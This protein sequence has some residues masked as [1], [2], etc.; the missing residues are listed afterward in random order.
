MKIEDEPLD[1]FYPKCCFCGA[2]LTGKCYRIEE[3]YY[4]TDCMAE[5]DGTEIAEEKRYAAFEDA[6]EHLYAD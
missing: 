2:T 1:G 5:V 3:M 6:Q 4:C